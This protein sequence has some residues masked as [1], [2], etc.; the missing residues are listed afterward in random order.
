MSFIN[1]T[2]NAPQPDDATLC[3]FYFING[4]TA[5]CIVY[6]ES[7]D[8]V[9]QTVINSKLFFGPATPFYPEVVTPANPPSEPIPHQSNPLDLVKFKQALGLDIESALDDGGKIKSRTRIYLST[10]IA[11]A[12]AAGLK[13]LDITTLPTE[14]LDDICSIAI[15]I[16]MRPHY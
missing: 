7:C 13:E 6:P 11:S 14:D 15:K 3:R 16:H 9:I 4:A 2:A 5:G 12:F 8:N 10:V 1:T